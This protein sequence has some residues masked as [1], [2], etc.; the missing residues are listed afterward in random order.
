MLASWSP[1]SGVLLESFWSPSCSLRQRQKFSH[2]KSGRRLFFAPVPWER[3]NLAVEVDCCVLPAVI[4]I[5]SESARHQTSV[6]W[7]KQFPM[8]GPLASC[9]CR[10]SVSSHGCWA[11]VHLQLA[12]VI[13]PR[14]WR[15][16]LLGSAHSQRRI[17]GLYSMLFA[18]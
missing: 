5:I 14:S 1:P 7:R 9:K 11:M 3:E 12:V 10:R 13:Y 8:S 15:R 18:A 4:S 16:S 2:H 17:C 6:E